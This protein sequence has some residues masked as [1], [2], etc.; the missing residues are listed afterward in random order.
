MKHTIKQTQAAFNRLVA[1][2]NAWRADFQAAYN[3]GLLTKTSY[4][5]K[6]EKANQLRRDLH[7][8]GLALTETINHTKGDTDETHD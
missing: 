3:S 8:V 7:V 4:A 1:F 5:D 6:T 2:E